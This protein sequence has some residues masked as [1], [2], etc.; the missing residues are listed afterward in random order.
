MT[1]LG[2][3][4]IIDSTSPDSGDPELKGDC[5][6]K[7]KKKMTRRKFLKWLTAGG[8]VGLGGIALDAFVIEPHGFKIT[9]HTI[10]LP[11]LPQEWD[12][13]TIA[14]VTDL[15][16]GKL[17]DLD[18]ARE[19]VNMTNQLHPDLIVLTGDFV[20]R[21][22]SISPALSEVLRD[23]HAPMGK[24]AVLGNHEYWTDSP[25]IIATFEAVGIKFL[26]N[27]NHV[28]TRNGKALV[29]GGVDDFMEGNPDVLRAFSGI[30]ENVPRI[31][32]CHNPDY[33]EAMPAESN[34]DLML[35]GHTHGGQV[36]IPL[37]GP[38]LVPI[39][40]RKYAEGLVDG[41]HCPVFVS[42]GLGMVEIPVRFNC[43]PEI[44]LIT[45]RAK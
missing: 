15:H 26:T 34:V 21:A 30:D 5:L 4:E 18:N 23:L 29:L 25:K 36:K 9:K 43:P 35:C 10:T 12:G 2:E 41:P 16:I 32:L 20:S 27:D 44:P 7:P 40:H 42:R 28:F 31:L 14:H 11:R 3:Q 38:P 37:I 19:I 24:F 6:Q 8:V 22:D 13:L 39:D 17:S 1:E 45:L 33:A